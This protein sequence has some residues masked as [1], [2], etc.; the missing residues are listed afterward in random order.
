[1]IYRA[2]YIVLNVSSNEPQKICNVIK[3]MVSSCLCNFQ[4]N[5]K[6]YA[7]GT[8]VNVTKHNM[9]S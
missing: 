7:R 8:L 1:M 5:I 6:Y 2:V 9:K 4:G 3:A